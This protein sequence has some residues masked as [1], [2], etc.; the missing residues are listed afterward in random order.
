MSIRADIALEA[1]AWNA[2]FES[3]DRN[4]TF[5]LSTDRV[6]NGPGQDLRAVRADLRFRTLLEANLGHG[7]VMTFQE[8]IAAIKERIAKAESDCETWRAAGEGEKYLEAYF[9]A[10]ALELQLENRLRQPSR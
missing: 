4:R 7:A 5:G 9:L 10:E 6:W 3:I 8:D 1:G 2:L